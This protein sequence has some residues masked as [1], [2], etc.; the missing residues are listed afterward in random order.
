[1]RRLAGALITAV[2]IAGCGGGSGL[3]SPVA[4]RRQATDIC[5][6][7]S[8]IVPPANPT[9][10]AGLTSFLSRGT[11]NLEAERGQLRQLRVPAGEV[12]DIYG[13]AL[14]ALAKQIHALHTATASIRLG[15][16]PALAVKAL[17]AQLGPLQQQADSAWVS[18]QIPACVER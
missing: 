13:A 12:G 4:L 6:D 18:L 14:A 7:V 17:Q 10:V 3:A 11:A 9:L 15:Q 2:I 8:H 16:D 1:M 5:K